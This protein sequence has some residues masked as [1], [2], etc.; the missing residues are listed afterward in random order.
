MKT[1]KKRLV[2]VFLLITTML[3][4]AGSST[5]YVT[6]S[7]KKY[8]QRNCRTLS[9]SKNVTSVSIDVAKRR[10]YEPC[11]VCNP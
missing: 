7:G 5:V 10:G 6:A 1:T 8:H 9:K 11:K 3:F 4:A 2:I